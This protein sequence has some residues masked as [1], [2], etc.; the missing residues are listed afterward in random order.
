MKTVKNLKCID[1]ITVQR[2]TDGKKIL[3]K[4]L[5]AHFQSLLDTVR[6]IPDAFLR[7]GTLAEVTPPDGVKRQNAGGKSFLGTSQR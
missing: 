7:K 5:N 3:V 1:K 2:I 4:H 6:G